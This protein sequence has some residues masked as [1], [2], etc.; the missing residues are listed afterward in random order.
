MTRMNTKLTATVE[1]YLAD[2]RRVSASGGA[3]GATANATFSAALSSPKKSST[4]PIQQGELQ[5]Y[6]E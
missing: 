5:R 4:S 3:T 6:S 2:L 1:T